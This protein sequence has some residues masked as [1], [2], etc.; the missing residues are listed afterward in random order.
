MKD[1]SFDGV[2]ALARVFDERMK[3]TADKPLVLDFGV[4]QADY[5]LKTNTFS[6]PIPKDSYL[7]CRQ[8]TLGPTWDYLTSTIPIGKPGDGTHS[9]K[10]SGEHDGHTAGDG[11]H[12]HENE[13]P[14]VHT[15]LIPELM[16]SIKPGDRVLVAWVGNDAIVIDIIFPATEI[17]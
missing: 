7:V 11:K 13:G 15:V 3:K 4:I 14:H 17:R 12:S 8:V 5:S 16:R 9:H 10:D 6:Q 1:P 2:N